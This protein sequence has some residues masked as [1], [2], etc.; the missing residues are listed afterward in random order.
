MF[1]DLELKLV[2]DRQTRAQPG[3]MIVLLCTFDRFR[4]P[5]SA[6]VS[7]D[8]NKINYDNIQLDHLMSVGAFLVFF[9]AT[10]LQFALRAVV[11]RS[12]HNTQSIPKRLN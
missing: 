11:G 3:L 4:L 7:V 5:G 6:V 2:V 12:S 8:C 1:L 9:G 10:L